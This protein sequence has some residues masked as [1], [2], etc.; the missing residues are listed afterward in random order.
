MRTLKYTV[1]F[2]PATEGGYTVV[3]PALPGCVT[4]GDTLD[5][6][7]KMTTEAM[8][9]ASDASI[10]TV[11]HAYDPDGNYLGGDTWDNE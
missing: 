1:I 11:Y 4:E 6:A 9:L 7:R 3:V 5:E 8:E 2:E 10:A